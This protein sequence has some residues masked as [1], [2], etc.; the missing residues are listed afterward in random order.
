MAEATKEI[1]KEQFMERERSAWKEAARRI[2]FFAE[3]VC[4]K[5]DKTLVKDASA[6]MTDA[7]G[8]FKPLFRQRMTIEFVDK[9]HG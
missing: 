7:I 2:E 3:L 6:K 4:A 5:T 9:Q 8:K 1:T